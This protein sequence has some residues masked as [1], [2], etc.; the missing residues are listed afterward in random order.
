[1][2]KFSMGAVWADV[3]AYRRTY[4]L[5]AVASFGGMVRRIDAVRVMYT[6][7]GLVA[8]WMGHRTDWRR[9]DHGRLPAFV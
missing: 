3:K 4:L 2:A 8:V 1:M 6:N 9:S 7:S 5:T